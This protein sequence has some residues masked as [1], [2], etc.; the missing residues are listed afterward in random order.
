V[1][2]VKSRCAWN[3]FAVN[4]ERA[5]AFLYAVL[6]VVF[7]FTYE[8]SALDDE[9]L[10][11]TYLAVAVLVQPVTGFLIPRL[12]AFALGVSLPISEPVEP[13][14]GITVR[15]DVHLRHRRES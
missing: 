13:G 10:G 9:I 5:T 14:H 8:S 15:G 3:S 6:A 4:V 12:W 11:W 2:G 7:V 1:F